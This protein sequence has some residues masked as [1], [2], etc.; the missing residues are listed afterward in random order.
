MNLDSDP[1]SRF[2]D[3]VGAGKTP[4]KKLSTDSFL[5]VLDG[6]MKKPVRF[7]IEL[8]P[9][10]RLQRL[11]FVSIVLGFLITANTVFASAAAAQK[12]IVFIGDSITAGYGVKKEEAFPEKIGEMLK[13]RGHDVKIINGGISGSVSAEADRRVRWFLKAKPDLIVLALGGNDGL[14]GTPPDVIEKN[15]SDAIE[16]AQKNGIKILLVGQKIYSN[17]GSEYTKKFEALFTHLAKARKVPFV[18]FLLEPV[19]MKPELNQ[20][21]MKHPNPAGH[22]K[23]AEHLLSQIEGLL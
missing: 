12:T 8:A 11:T 21:D 20:T 15:L 14:K 1:R 2:H 6:V 5:K 4:L 10:L 22:V 3:Y 9:H 7:F 13:V 17:L 18:P 19:A 16:V 23:V